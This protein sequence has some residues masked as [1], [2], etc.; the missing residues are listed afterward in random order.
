[1]NT[2]VVTVEMDDSLDTIRD[3]FQRVRFHHVLV[4][5]GRKLVG[6]ISDRDLLKAIS[7]FVGT[8]SETTRDRDTLNKR[9]HQIMSR[10]P[11]TVSKETRLKDALKILLD[12][13]ISCL[14]I[15]NADGEVEGIVT[16]KDMLKAV[17]VSSERSP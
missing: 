9:A 8:L 12:K 15:I 13:N 5:S 16:W 2:R 7:P 17:L 3:I 6:V 11:V 10:Q 1:M 14:P 4:V